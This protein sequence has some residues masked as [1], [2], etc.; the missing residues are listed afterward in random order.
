MRVHAPRPPIASIA[1][2]TAAILTIIGLIIALRWV[3]RELTRSTRRARDQVLDSFIDLGVKADW[4]VFVLL[5]LLLAWLS[6]GPFFHHPSPGGQE[7]VATL[8][9]PAAER[10]ADRVLGR[11]GPLAGAAS[12]D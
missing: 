8:A 5:Q 12:R 3:L 2:I 7:G 4:T 1:V 6:Y 9:G 10:P 11:A